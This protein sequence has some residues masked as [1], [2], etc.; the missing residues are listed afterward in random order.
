MDKFFS[1][2]PDNGFDTYETEEEARKGAEEAID[3]WL[4][5]SIYSGLAEETEEICYG[6]IIAKAKIEEFEPKKPVCGRHDRC[7]GCSEFIDGDCKDYD[8]DC[9]GEKHTDSHLEPVRDDIQKGVDV[10]G[11]VRRYLIDNGFDG[12]QGPECDCTLDNLMP[13]STDGTCISNESP[14][15]CK[16]GHRVECKHECGSQGRCIGRCH[17]IPDANRK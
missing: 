10:R 15:E 5:A 11:I 8:S 2:E 6:R 16:P 14:A 4:K 17:L 3:S 12:L 13:C 1:Y 9:D 7:V